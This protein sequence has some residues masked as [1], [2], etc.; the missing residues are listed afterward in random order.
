MRITIRLSFFL[1]LALVSAAACMAIV[2]TEPPESTSPPAGR[3]VI[4]TW[5]EENP[6]GIR[7]TIYREGGRVFMETVDGDGSSETAEMIETTLP[8]NTRFDYEDGRGG[9]YYLIA[10]NGDLRGWTPDGPFLTARP[11]E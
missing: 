4:G 10:T 6:S 9:G 8:R 7:T 2:E 11:V 5:L 1:V 3:E